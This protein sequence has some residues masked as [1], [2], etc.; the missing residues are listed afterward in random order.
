M[1]LEGKAFR[2]ALA[3][4]THLIKLVDVDYRVTRLL[5]PS[6]ALAFGGRAGYRAIGNPKRVRKIQVVDAR[7]P[8]VADPSHWDDRGCLRYSPLQFSEE[9]AT[10]VAECPVTV[11]RTRRKPQPKMNPARVGEYNKLAVRE[12]AARERAAGLA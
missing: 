6:E 5:T 10:T 8:N 3:V 11:A 4:Q 12:R 1:I 9:M 2:D 7:R